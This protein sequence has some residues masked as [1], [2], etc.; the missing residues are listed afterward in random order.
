MIM[1]TVLIWIWN[2]GLDT[3]GYTV[4]MLEAT[5]TGQICIGERVNIR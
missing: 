3:Y 2:K 1:G 5:C 4:D